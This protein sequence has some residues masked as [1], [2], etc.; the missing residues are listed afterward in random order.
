MFI[1]QQLFI[2][3]KERKKNR[4]AQLSKQK[5]F[6]LHLELAYNNI[7]KHKTRKLLLYEHFTATIHN[8]IPSNNISWEHLV[9]IHNVLP[10]LLNQQ[11]NQT[12]DLQKKPTSFVIR[13]HA[14]DTNWNT[15][16]T[17]SRKK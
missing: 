4:E 12:Q 1:V 2:L 6:R 16:N 8:I 11:Y 10:L 3:S 15:Q 13:T 7:Y 17:D 9:Y 14:D 5:A